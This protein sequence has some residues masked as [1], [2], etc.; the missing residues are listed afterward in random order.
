MAQ[1]KFIIKNGAVIES[2]LAGETV[3]DVQKTDKS[4]IFDINSN[5][6]INLIGNINPSGNFINKLKISNGGIS[7][8]GVTTGE[9]IFYDSTGGIV[10]IGKNTGDQDLSNLSTYTYVDNTFLKLAGGTMTGSLYVNNSTNSTSTTT[11][12]IRTAGGLGVVGNA[13]VGGTLNSTGIANVSAI[14]TSN[15]DNYSLI[16]RG[17]SSNPALYVQNSTTGA[18]QIATFRYGS[19]TAGGGT[20]VLNISSNLI[21]I[22]T[23]FSVSNTSTFNGRLKFNGDYGPCIDSSSNLT[24]GIGGNNMIAI[25]GTE[26]RPVSAYNNLINL[27]GSATRWLTTYT[28]NLNLNGTIVGATSGV[29]SSTIQATTVKLTNLTDGYIPYHVSDSSGLSDSPIYTN[30]TNVI[31]GSSTDN[32]SGKLQING[33]LN[34]SGNVGFGSTTNKCQMVYD[35]NENSIDF[36][37]N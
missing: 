5:G 15:D 23:D 34:V 27:G 21:N 20:E 33:N 10:L 32:N 19:A 35:T 37:I 1:D 24:F 31:V 4:S 30:S 16:F 12:A 9:T 14:R 25:V 8:T 28:N 3:F 17:G 18:T 13:Y 11:G 7:V 6:T 36:I 2:V 22:K 26:F 29:F